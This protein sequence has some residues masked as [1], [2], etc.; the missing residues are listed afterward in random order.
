MVI[1][2]ANIVDVIQRL[3]PKKNT[4]EIGSVPVLECNKET[5]NL[6]WWAR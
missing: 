4:S 1:Y 6:L 3:S 2:V 5:E